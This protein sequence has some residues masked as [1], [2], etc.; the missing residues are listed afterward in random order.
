MNDEDRS[1]FDQLLHTH[2]QEFGCKFEDVV[3]YQPLLYG[4]LMLPGPVK[5][6]Q[7]ME[8]REKVELHYIAIHLFGLAETIITFSIAYI[9]ATFTALFVLW[10]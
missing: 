2:I 1:W 8:D 6:Y 10:P 9:S 3:P 4:D 7:L 5:V